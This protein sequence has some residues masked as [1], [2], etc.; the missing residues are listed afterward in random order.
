MDDKLT[1]FQEYCKPIFENA[2]DGLV[3]VD[4]RTKKFIAENPAFC[5]MSGWRL[6]NSELQTS[7][8]RIRYRLA[9]S[10]L[11]NHFVPRFR[12]LRISP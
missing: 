4:M 3:I 2:N 8:Q 5:K 11:K 12:W 6:G 7:I 1:E 9:W 10:K